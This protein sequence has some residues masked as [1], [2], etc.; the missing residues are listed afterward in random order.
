M[1]R[2]LSKLVK[3]GE[4]IRVGCISNLA[5]VEISKIMAFDINCQ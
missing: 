5:L 2:E 3:M 4:N 1:L